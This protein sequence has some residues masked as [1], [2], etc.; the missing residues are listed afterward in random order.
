MTPSLVTGTSV[1]SSTAPE[2]GQLADLR[3]RQRITSDVDASEVAL[4]IEPKATT[5]RSATAK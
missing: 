5:S 1:L 4:R 2:P 3:R